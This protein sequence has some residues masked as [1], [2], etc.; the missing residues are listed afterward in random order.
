M[1][2]TNALL[3]RVQALHELPDPAMQRALRKA[4]RA[5]LAEVADAVGVTRQAVSMWELGQRSPSPQHL[6]AY[7]DVLR[8]FRRVVAGT[9]EMREAGFPASEPLADNKRRAKPTARA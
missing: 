8:M 6:E 2:S 9:P 3:A 4:V 5:S 7:V 1:T